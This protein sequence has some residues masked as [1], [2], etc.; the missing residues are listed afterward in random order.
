MEVLPKGEGYAHPQILGAEQV[1]REERSVPGL[2]RLACRAEEV[3]RRSRLE[4]AI[5][6]AHASS[7]APTSI[8]TY[9]RAPQR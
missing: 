1:W 9:E 6:R 8:G 7:R 4:T 3:Q 5:H 2:G